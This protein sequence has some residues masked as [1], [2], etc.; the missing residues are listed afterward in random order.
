MRDE[1]LSEE[2]LDVRNMGEAELMAWWQRWL[3]L[4]QATNDQDEH[5]YSHGVWR[6]DPTTLLG[7][8]PEQS[9]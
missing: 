9:D 1:F 3:E 5:T 8:E 2:D 7:E 4:A 6:V